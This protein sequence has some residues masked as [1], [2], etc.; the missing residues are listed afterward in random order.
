MPKRPFGRTIAPERDIRMLMNESAA[1]SVRFRRR[2]WDV[3]RSALVVGLIL[4]AAHSY[5]TRRVADGQAPRIDAVALDGRAVRVPSGDG[6]PRLVRF[7]ATWCGVC[8]A[9]EHNVRALAGSGELVLVASSSGTADDVR[10]YAKEHALDVPIVLDDGSLRK[11]FGVSSYPTSFFVD[12][13]GEIQ[14]VTVGYTT[15][16]GMRL[17]MMATR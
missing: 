14:F 6:S 5:A 10:A 11:A 8:K 17:R 13:R 15:E 16:L 9:E 2:A 1:R 7:F 3:A 4:T 12:A